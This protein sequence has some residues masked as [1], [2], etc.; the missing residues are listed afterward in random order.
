MQLIDPPET[1]QEWVSCRTTKFIR[2]DLVPLAEEAQR[3]GER[4]GRN[5]NCKGNLDAVHIRF[6][7]AR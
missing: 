1:W 6:K 7:N 4:R 5:C 2:V 3:K